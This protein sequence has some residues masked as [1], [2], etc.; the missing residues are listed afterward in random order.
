MNLLFI[1]GPPAVGK[2]TIAEELAYLTGYKLFH[3]HLTMD[4]AK[5]IYPE[6]NEM[7]FKLV[8]T[9]R[10]NVFEYAAK[11]NTDLIFT[12]VHDGDTVDDTFTKETVAIIERSGGNVYFVELTASDDIL[13]ERV[14]N[15]S[16][17]R[18]HKLKDPHIL[19]NQLAQNLYRTPL[20]YSNILKI[21]T[22]TINPSQTAKE[23]VTHF[24]LP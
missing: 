20:P 11:N 12:F 4:L 6:F 10:L 23:I 1:Y 3:N 19:K 2:L 8:D 14:S 9:L 22:S 7:R 13:L 21:D 18:F 15:E 16:R 24:K 5:E 17:K